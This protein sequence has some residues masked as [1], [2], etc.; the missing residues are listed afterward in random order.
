MYRKR[1][2]K[3][4]KETFLKEFIEFTGKLVASREFKDRKNLQLSEVPLKF[5]LNS[6]LICKD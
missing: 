2:V 1:G 3:D 4:I 6:K 5:H